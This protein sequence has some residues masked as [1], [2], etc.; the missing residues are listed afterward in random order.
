MAEPNLS[1][2]FDHIN[3]RAYAV[4]QQH[5]AT[6]AQLK[7]YSVDNLIAINGIGK[8]W[9]TDI[10]AALISLDDGS[11]ETAEQ[12]L[13]TDAESAEQKMSGAES[14]D[15][16]YSTTTEP[17]PIALAHAPI[18]DLTDDEAEI[19]LEAILT[20]NGSDDEPTAIELPAPEPQADRTEPPPTIEPI[21]ISDLAV[22]VNMIGD[23]S[24]PPPTDET[25]L[26]MAMRYL[27]ACGREADVEVLLGKVDRDGAELVVETA[28]AILEGLPGGELP[29][30]LAAEVRARSSEYGFG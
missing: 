1:P 17:T 24:A 4:L 23:P 6:L 10:H 15:W 13:L 20:P 18:A 19:L 22:I 12:N 21:T 2:L 9:A 26:A 30:N 27:R 5:G 16:E 8:R 11:A 14:P 29:R 25:P 28:I 3:A 7:D